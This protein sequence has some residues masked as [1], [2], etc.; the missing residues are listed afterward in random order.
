MT[1]MVRVIADNH[2]PRHVGTR[3]FGAV[4]DGIEARVVDDAGVVV[5]I[6]SESDLIAEPNIDIIMVD[7]NEMG[8]AVEGL[9]NY[10]ILEIIDHHR[11]GDITTGNPI[12]FKNEPVG[13]TSTIIAALY[14]EAAHEVAQVNARA[15][16]LDAEIE[17]AMA[18]WEDLETRAAGG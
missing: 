17:A 4:F 11:L 6:F 7:H 5:G 3:A 18:R 12:Y 10:R 15:Q 16:A 14:Q 13:S 9:E 1:E 8:Q 2:P